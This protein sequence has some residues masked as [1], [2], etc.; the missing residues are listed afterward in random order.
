M[1][2]KAL[3]GRASQVAFSSATNVVARNQMQP[4]VM[5][6]LLDAHQRFSGCTAV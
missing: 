4:V 6:A 5:K 3:F 1:N 2:A